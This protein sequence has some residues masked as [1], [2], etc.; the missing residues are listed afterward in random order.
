MPTALF[1]EDE[2]LRIS[3]AMRISAITHDDERCTIACAA[4][5]TIV[6][7]LITG[8]EPSQAVQ[9][10]IDVAKTLEFGKEGLVQ[11]SIIL[12]RTL[13]VNDLAENGPKPALPNSAS[14]YVLESLTIAISALFDTRSLVD[15]L[16][17]IV[18]IGKDTDTNAAIAG[19]LLGARDGA[20]AIPTAWID[21]LQFGQEFISIALELTAS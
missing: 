5:V 17:D 7:A 18:R 2:E 14:G 9:R 12:G 15:V 3:E 8:V 1:Q 11:E 10:G 21:K 16:S 20:A 6:Y 13:K 19:G 4:Y